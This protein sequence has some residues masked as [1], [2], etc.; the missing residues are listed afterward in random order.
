MTQLSA[1]KPEIFFDKITPNRDYIVRLSIDGPNH[2]LKI[3]DIGSMYPLGE[4]RTVLSE[5]DSM[6]GFAC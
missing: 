6:I 3:Y 4:I 2:I 1:A 5:N